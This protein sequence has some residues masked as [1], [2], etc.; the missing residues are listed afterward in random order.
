LLDP[1]IAKY[2]DL[3]ENDENV[4]VEV[5]QKRCS[6]QNLFPVGHMLSSVESKH[7]KYNN[8]NTIMTNSAI[9]GASPTLAGAKGHS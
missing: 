9:V 7:N 3:N 1:K 6:Q 8:N 5:N 2:F 4:T